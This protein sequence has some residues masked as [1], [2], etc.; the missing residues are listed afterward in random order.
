MAWS[1][2]QA[3]V[4]LGAKQVSEGWP[5][6]AQ[7]VFK[8]RGATRPPAGLA[9]TVATLTL[10]LTGDPKGW[11]QW[12]ESL[13]APPKRPLTGRDPASPARTASAG[14]EGLQKKEQELPATRLKTWK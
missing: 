3:S 11:G 1:H 8:P 2:V 13:P 4:L 9:R 10:A 7:R 14:T 5:S 12:A 6:G